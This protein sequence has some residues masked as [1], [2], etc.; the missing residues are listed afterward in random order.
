MA[1]HGEAGDCSERH[2]IE[3]DDND[4]S[5]DSSDDEDHLA[6]QARRAAEEEQGEPAP[7]VK[8]G[9]LGNEE[10]DSDALFEQLEGAGAL[11]L[12]RPQQ[13]RNSQ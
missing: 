11:S 7:E 13:T 12:S 2:D 9:E 5:A 8:A 4:E 3:D 6:R 1:N 10:G